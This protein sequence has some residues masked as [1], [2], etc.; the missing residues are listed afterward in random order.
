MKTAFL[1]SFRLVS[2][3]WSILMMAAAFS[4]ES[5]AVQYLRVSENNRF[6]VQEDGQPFFWLGDTAW[7]LFHRLGKADTEHYLKTR[8]QQGFNMVQCVLLAESNGLTVPTPEGHVP[9][10]DIDPTQPNEAY[11]KHVD[12]VVSKATEL[13][14]YLAILPTWGSNV[15]GQ[16]LFNE[17]N[18][19]AYGEF[20]GRRY[21]DC[22][23]IVW[24]LG[25]D[26]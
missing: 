17:A 1:P 16:G 21:R 14:V 10:V 3:F 4:S 24:V 20:L 23:N 25:G 12:W 11:F 5:S 7:E 13:G 15:Q 6:L 22:C 9:L 8:A 2:I 19:R 26:R 18:A